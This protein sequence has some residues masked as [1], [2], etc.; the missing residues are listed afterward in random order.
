MSAYGEV[1]FVGKDSSIIPTSKNRPALP[2]PLKIRSFLDTGK[3][4]LAV[5]LHATTDE[6]RDWIVPTN[7]RYPIHQLIGLLKERFPIEKAKGDK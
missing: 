5:S 4:K 1:G 7:R 6:V 2:L 3:A